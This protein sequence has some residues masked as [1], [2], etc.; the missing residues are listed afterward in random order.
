[1]RATSFAFLGGAFLIACAATDTVRDETE[2]SNDG[3]TS[4]T[5]SAPSPKPMELVNYCKALPGV[6]ANGILECLKGAAASPTPA[7]L[8]N[9]CSA[10]PGTNAQGVLTC[11]ANGGPSTKPDVLVNY[12]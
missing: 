5:S 4:C 11:I 8:V 7:V 10:L 3:L 2:S 9:Y 1:M 12:C 6:S